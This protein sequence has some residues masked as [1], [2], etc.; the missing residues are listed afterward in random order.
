VAA[1][2]EPFGED[3]RLASYA[4][5]LAGFAPTSSQPRAP[6]EDFLARADAF[7]AA[8][9][10][11]LEV[12]SGRWARGDWDHVTHRAAALYDVE[13]IRRGHVR[14]LTGLK[15]LEAAFFTQ[16]YES[17]PSETA[18]FWRAVEAA[19]LPFARRDLLAE[20]VAKGRITSRD[21]YEFATDAV[22]LAG[23][24]GGPTEAQAAQLKAMIG[25]YERRGR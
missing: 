12:V 9:E 1:L 21:H 7:L 15:D 14:S 20:I 24:D 18:A 8:H 16:W 10:I 17:P 19:G 4:M 6:K 3:P 11:A 13:L 23:E 2:G 25:A 22:G 5:A